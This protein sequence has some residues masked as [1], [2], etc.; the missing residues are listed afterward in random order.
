MVSKLPFPNEWAAAE[1]INFPVRRCKSA[2]SDCVVVWPPE[3][4]RQ[5]KRGDPLNAKATG[6]SKL[7]VKNYTRMT[8]FT[9]DNNLGM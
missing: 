3:E 6:V 1:Q 8:I 9:L 2:L 5:V 4:L 7:V